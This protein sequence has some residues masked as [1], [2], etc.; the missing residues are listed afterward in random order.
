[1]WEWIVVYR[2][3]GM[4]IGEIDHFGPADLHENIIFKLSSGSEMGSSTVLRWIMTGAGG[5][6]W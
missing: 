5:R 2:L 6:N 4:E 3:L 1:M